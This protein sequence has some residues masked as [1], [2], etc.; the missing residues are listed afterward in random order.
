[1][2]LNS[3]ISWLANSTRHLNL[4]NRREDNGPSELAEVVVDLLR[5]MPSGGLGSGGWLQEAALRRLINVAFFTSLAPEEGRYPRCSLFWSIYFH[6]WFDTCEFR[7]E[8]AL[9]VETLRRL[10]PICQTRGSAIRVALRDNELLLVGMTATRFEGLDMHPGR[11]GFASTG[12][13]PNVQVHI[14]APGHIRVDCGWTEFELCAG[15]LRQ[16]PDLRSLP[17]V[18]TLTTEF[19]RQSVMK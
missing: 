11:P 2:T 9:D 12:R 14:L 6:E 18:E 4:S 8:K 5:G 19:G 13:E 16:C 3:Y 7:P 15:Q 1:M 10:A 17:C